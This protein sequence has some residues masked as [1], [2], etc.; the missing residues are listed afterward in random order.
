MRDGAISEQVRFAAAKELLD[1]AYGGPRQKIELKNNV[2]TV[3][4]QR[5]RS[6]VLEVP[7]TRPDHPIDDAV[8]VH[9]P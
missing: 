3:I 5:E 8:I 9:S 2:V 1:R 7:P 6:T 4:V